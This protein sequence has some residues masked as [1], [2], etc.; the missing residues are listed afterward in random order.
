MARD[1]AFVDQTGAA[2]DREVTCAIQRGIT[3][4]ANSHF[5]YGRF[6]GAI[7]HF[8]RTLADAL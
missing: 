4:G 5:T 2:E 7:V 8:H 1:A 6:E 3:S